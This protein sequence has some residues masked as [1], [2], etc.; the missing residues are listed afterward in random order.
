MTKI[1]VVYSRAAHGIEAPLV[2][3]ETH[4]SNGLP[5]LSIVGLAEATVKET[6][7][8]VRSAI[9]N[10]GFEFPSRRITINLA[11]ADLPKAG[12][13]FD[14]PIS[15]GILIASEQIKPLDLET[16]EFAGELALSGRLRP[17]KGVLAV[18][19]SARTAQRNLIIPIE[20]AFEAAMPQD[21]K[22]YPA[23]NLLEVCAHI[24]AS[25]I[26]PK[27]HFAATT[28]FAEPTMN[29]MQDIVGQRHAKRVLEIAAA[30]QHSVL[31]MGPPGT[32]KTMLASRLPTILPELT[33][34][35]ALEVAAI[36]GLKQ[37]S[38]LT[39]NWR[40]RPFR[41]PHHTTS[42]IAMVGGGSD[43]QPGEISL[44]HNG[45]LFLDE[46]P[47][48][49][50]RVL[51]VLREPLETNNITI[52][53]AKRKICFPAKFQLLAAMNP[54]PCGHLYNKNKD[55]ICSSA[56]ILRYQSKVSGPLLERIDLHI[57]V[58]LLPIESLTNHTHDNNES[59][60]IVKQRVQNAL[61]K[62]QQRSN[63]TNSLLSN[64]EIKNVCVLNPECRKIIGKAVETFNLS[65]RSFYRILK[66]ART[67]ADLDE[68]PSIETLHLTEALGYRS[69]LGVT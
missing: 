12:G 66:V 57:E 8:R 49:D 13:R 30:G 4:I 16:Y 58:P 3:V 28:F 21:N 14:L 23:H 36:Y 10:S 69:K 39:P 5:R 64:L 65:A 61:Y 35:E 9:I 25:K 47:E 15:L 24:Q 29:D 62:Q 32:G 17:F 41:A 56:Q 38:I 6:K 54:C 18:A 33:V 11:P 53:R 7:D 42:A 40:Q 51:E 26:I 67:I 59:S 50:R 20:N 60:A 52:S 46:F 31:L 48:F 68:S 44:A 45:V 19:I 43:P 2:N 55:C 1:A 63:K 27:Y 34:N 22:I 37:T